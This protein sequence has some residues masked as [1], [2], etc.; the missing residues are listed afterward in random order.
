[1]KT[2]LKNLIKMY[3]SDIKNLEDEE[4]LESI[5]ETEVLERVIDDLNKI[6]KNKN[7]YAT[8]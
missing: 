7:N 4:Y 1:M 3:L 5:T 6:I 8:R 2:E